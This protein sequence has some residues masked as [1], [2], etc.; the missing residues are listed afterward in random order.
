MEKQTKFINSFGQLE[1]NRYMGEGGR[2]GEGGGGGG[3]IGGLGGREEGGGR[4]KSMR[5]QY[6]RLPRQRIEKGGGG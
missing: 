2:D 1:L 3:G 5:A 4:E 6:D